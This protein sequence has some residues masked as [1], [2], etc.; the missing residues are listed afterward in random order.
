MKPSL[1]THFGKFYR[2]RTY[3]YAIEIINEKRELL[4]GDIL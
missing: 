2:R 1:K 3:L 4:T